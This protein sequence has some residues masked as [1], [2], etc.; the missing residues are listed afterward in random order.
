MD[1]YKVI[2]VE[3]EPIARKKLISLLGNFSN[4]IELIAEA[5]NGIVAV[6]KINTLKPDLIFLDIQMPG[7]TGFEVLQKLEYL[8]LVIFT[9][10]YDKYALQAFESNTIDYLLKPISLAKLSKSIG[11]LQSFSKKNN[12]EDKVQNLLKEV[13][14][15]ESKIAVTLSDRIIFL[16]PEDIYFIKADN[17]Y[18]EIHLKDKKYLISKSLNELEKQLGNNF[19][20]LHRSNLVNREHISEV[21]KLS[22]RKWI[23]KLSDAKNTELPISRDYKEKLF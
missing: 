2:V 8:P 7:L 10:A 18:S 17:K 19:V 9:T 6:E 3:D 20:R 4:A 22:S 11:K 15:M 1:K 5:E 23:A 16:S 21:I 12:W 13:L 14:K